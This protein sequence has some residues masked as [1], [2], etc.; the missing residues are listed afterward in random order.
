MRWV[1]VPHSS[2]SLDKA[3]EAEERMHPLCLSRHRKVYAG[4]HPIMEAVHESHMLKEVRRMRIRQTL[5]KI[6]SDFLLKEHAEYEQ[7]FVCRRESERKTI[8]ISKYLIYYLHCESW[9][10]RGEFV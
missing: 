7:Q 3:R 9:A 10:T 4:K 2:L 6:Q 1:Q 5:D 8:S